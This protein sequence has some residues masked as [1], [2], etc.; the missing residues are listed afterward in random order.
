MDS[1]SELPNLKVMSRNAVFRYK[2]KEADARAVGRELGVRAVLLGRITQRGDNLSIS[3]EL[4]DVDDNSHLWGEQYTRKLAD[5]LAVQKRDRR[6][7]FGQ[8]AAQA[9]RA[10]RRRGWPSAKP[11]IRRRISFISRAASTPPS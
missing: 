3:A 5:A 4:V 7:D 2:G 10:S 9:E 6:A 1:L 11:R 8:A